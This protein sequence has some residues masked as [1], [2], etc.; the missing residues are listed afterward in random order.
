[1]VRRDHG[2][3]P[4]RDGLAKCSF[5]ADTEHPRHECAR[6]QAVELYYNTEESKEGARAFLEKRPPKFR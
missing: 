6:V 5:N 1:M 2:E 3:E 4:D